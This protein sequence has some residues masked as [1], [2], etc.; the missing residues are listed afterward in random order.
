MKIPSRE[1]KFLLDQRS[2]R[3][4]FIGGVDRKVSDQ[5]LRK[6]LR[7]E[8]LQIRREKEEPYFVSDQENRFSSSTSSSLFEQVSVPQNEAYKPLFEKLSS[9]RNLQKIER[10]A[11]E[12]DRYNISNRAATLI[13]FNIITEECTEDVIDHHKI[14]RARKNKEEIFQQK[15]ATIQV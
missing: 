5:I 3:K 11:I 14:W 2:E 4:M 1:R 8:R 15:K 12:A 13:D 10:I 9:T 6:N 7:E